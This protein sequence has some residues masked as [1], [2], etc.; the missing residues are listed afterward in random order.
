M[1]EKIAEQRSR[2][3]ALAK[4]SVAPS[5]QSSDG[6]MFEKTVKWSV[7]ERRRDLVTTVRAK[8]HSR[9]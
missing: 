7:G 2:V 4:Q 1:F 3:P 5:C 6:W 9:Q 8:P